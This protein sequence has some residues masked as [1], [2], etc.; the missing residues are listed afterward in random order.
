MSRYFDIF[1]VTYASIGQTDGDLVVAKNASRRLRVA[2]VVKD[3][4]LVRRDARGDESASVL[5]FGDERANN[6]DTRGV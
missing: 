4:S 5:R 1:N 3:L 6:R 2:Y